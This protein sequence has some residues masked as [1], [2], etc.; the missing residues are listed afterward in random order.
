MANLTQLL[1]QRSVTGMQVTAGAAEETLLLTVDGAAPAAAIAI[2]EGTQFVL[3]DWMLCAPTPTVRG[4]LQQSNDNGANWF[5]LAVA[6]LP[7]GLTRRVGFKNPIKIVG[8]VNR[9]FREVIQTPGGGGQLVTSTL[10]I[11]NEP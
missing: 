6:I 8:A 7:G 11:S 3:T 1:S 10:R 9:L 4:R 5:D 2:P